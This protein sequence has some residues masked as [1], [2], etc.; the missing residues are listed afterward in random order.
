MAMIIVGTLPLRD[1][2]V[3]YSVCVCLFERE[4]ERGLK[5]GSECE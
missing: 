2:E 5:C 4:R 3:P 1:T